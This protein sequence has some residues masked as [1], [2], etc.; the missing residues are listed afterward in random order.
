MLSLTRRTLQ[1]AIVLYADLIEPFLKQHESRIDRALI[2]I[3]GRTKHTIAVYGKHLLQIVN[4][5]IADMISKAY[6]H[7]TE[8]L[9]SL[10]TNRIRYTGPDSYI[11]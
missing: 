10:K 8:M 9:A 1:G 11:R 5:L 6:S 2:E 4:K 3:Q 7:T